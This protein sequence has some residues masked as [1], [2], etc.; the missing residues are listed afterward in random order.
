[1][2]MSCRRPRLLAALFAVLSSVA[3]PGTSRVHAADVGHCYTFSS[4][5][6]YYYEDGS[7]FAHVTGSQS[8]YA[9]DVSDCVAIS[10]NEA[11]STAGNACI[12]ASIGRGTHGIG[13]GVVSW[14]VSW[15]DTELTSSGPVEQQYDC[16]DVG[17]G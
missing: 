1:M 6:G 2:K 7:Q 17:P 12:Q 9:Y 5:E 11:I 14:I 8:F 10:Q 4:A 13:Y 15:G 3:V 16:G